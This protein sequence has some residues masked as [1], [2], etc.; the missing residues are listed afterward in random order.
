MNPFLRL[1][2]ELAALYARQPFSEFA[3]YLLCL[4]QAAPG[5]VRQRTLAPA[6]ARMQGTA[7]MRVNG[8][9]LRIPLGQIAELLDGHDDTPTFGGL[10]EMY[11]SNVYLR[12]FKPGFRIGTV[13]D[14]G[15]NRGLFSLLAVKAYGAR[16]AVG[17]EPS[18]HFSPVADLLRRANDVADPAMPREEAFAGS[19]GGAGSVSMAELMKSHKLGQ[20][21][22]LKCDIEGGEFDVFLNGPD[23]LDRVGNIAMELHP[24]CGPVQEIVDQLQ[25][26]GFAVRVTD[27]FG[28]AADGGPPHYLYASRIGDLIEE[29]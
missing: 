14:L 26:K 19:K 3:G 2:S 8:Q 28:R 6:D 24:N 23:F 29:R 13:V 10:R 15:A 20:V 9:D 16:I 12:A 22:F 11:A 5:V 17:V 18:V 4:A 7:T 27:Q 25:L 1:A 21:D